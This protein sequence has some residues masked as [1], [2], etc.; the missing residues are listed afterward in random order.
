MQTVPTIKSRPV[1]SPVEIDQAVQQHLFIAEEGAFSTLSD[2]YQDCEG[3]K[4][5]WIVGQ[6]SADKLPKGCHFIDAQ[7]FEEA[8]GELFAKLP[9]SS[10]LYIAGIREAFVWDIHKLAIQAGLAPEQIK[11]LQP[12]S[13]ERRLFCTHCYTLTEGVTYTPFECPG[14]KRLLL[15]RDHFSRLHSAYVGVQINAEDPNDIPP[16]EELS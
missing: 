8:F 5:C 11:K 6:E 1:Y 14:C 10:N 12:L 15:V 4:S 13:N 7:S 16:K 2:L 9:I 3:E